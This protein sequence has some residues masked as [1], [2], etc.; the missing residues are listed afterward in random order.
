MEDIFNYY[1]RVNFSENE[2]EKVLNKIMEE[3]NF[4]P[5]KSYKIIETGYV[6]LD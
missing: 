2:I 5:V 4:H 1:S 3:Y 6:E